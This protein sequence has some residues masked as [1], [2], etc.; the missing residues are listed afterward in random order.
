MVVMFHNT[1]TTVT[2]H[3]HTNT[4][5]QLLLY[6]GQAANE[7]WVPTSMKVSSKHTI[8]THSFYPQ[9][10]PCDTDITLCT[11]VALLD[12]VEQGNFD[13]VEQLLESNSVT[14]LNMW[15]SICQTSTCTLTL[16][17]SPS[18]RTSED[19]FTLVDLAAMLGHHDITKLLLSRGARDSTR[20]ELRLFQKS[21]IARNRENMWKFEKF[22]SFYLQSPETRS[23][24]FVTFWSCC[25]TRS[26]NWT[27]SAMRWW[28]RT[29]VAAPAVWSVTWNGNWDNTSGKLTSSNGWKQTMK[30]QVSKTWTWEKISWDWETRCR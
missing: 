16:P 28:S 7:T 6:S 21:L 23:R 26:E 19:D 24:D 1:F 11:P 4:H 10:N 18:R 15:G 8:R 2:T 13:G 3:T 20:C 27:A 9:L 5:I 12:L 25:R 14:D 22:V 29:R 17:P 30:V